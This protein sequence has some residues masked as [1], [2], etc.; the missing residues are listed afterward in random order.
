MSSPTCFVLRR[1]ARSA[2]DFGAED[3]G[4]G[5]ERQIP[6]RLHAAEPVSSLPG[7]GLGGPPIIPP[8]TSLISLACVV[9]ASE[10]L[11]AVEGAMALRSR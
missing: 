7:V 5:P 11:R 10:M 3:N 8:S 2:P 4:F 1:E 6:G 9:K